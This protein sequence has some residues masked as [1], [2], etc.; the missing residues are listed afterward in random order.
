M[1]SCPIY[2]HS[3]FLSYLLLCKNER[4]YFFARRKILECHSLTK[5]KAFQYEC[6]FRITILKLL[7]AFSKDPACMRS[8]PRERPAPSYRGKREKGESEREK[9][10]V[11]AREGCRGAR[12]GHTCILE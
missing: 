5:I 11:F 10:A 12:A 6:V 3:Y 2:T 9:T 7:M 8:F 4:E 1:R